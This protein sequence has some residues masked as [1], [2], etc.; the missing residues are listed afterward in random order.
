MLRPLKVTLLNVPEGEVSW[1]EA[2]DFP[3]DRAAGTH[4]VALGRTVY[5]EADDYRDEDSADYYGL[6]PGKVAGLRY[7]GYVKVVEVVRD[8]AGKAVEL[9]CDYDAGRSP[10]AGKVKGNLHWVSA[11]TPG[12]EPATAEVRLY[13][14][15]FTTEVPGETG[16][17]EAEMSA[18]SEVVLPRCYVDASLADAATLAKADGRFQFERLGFFV[19][20]RDADVAAGRLVFNQTVSL[21]EDTATKKVRG[22]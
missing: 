8:A 13:E 10:A 15:L 16:D 4:R 12:G 6:A 22:K 14:A 3:R 18:T 20:D 7:G 17:W 1:L 11:S 9:R 19:L 5:V 21:K 2:P